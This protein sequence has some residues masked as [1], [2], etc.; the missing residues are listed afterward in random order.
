MPRRLPSFAMF[1]ASLISGV[2]AVMPSISYPPRRTTVF[3]R[4][5]LDGRV[6]DRHRVPRLA[7]HRGQIAQPERNV[8]P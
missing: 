1:Q 7:Q 8:L 6:V 4:L 3:Q 5:I 2:A